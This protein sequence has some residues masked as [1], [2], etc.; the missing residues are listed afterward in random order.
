MFGF[1]RRKKTLDEV[2]NDRTEVN[3]CGVDFVIRKVN[4]LDHAKGLDVMLSEFDTYKLAKGEQKLTDGQMKKVRKHYRDIFLAGVVSP[5][6]S[7]K[8]EEGATLVDD[9]FNDP[10]LSETLYI[11]IMFHTYGKKKFNRKALTEGELLI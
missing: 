7:L 1:F 2:V 8:E 10:V 5:K 9:L 11:E 4:P 3:V 6:L